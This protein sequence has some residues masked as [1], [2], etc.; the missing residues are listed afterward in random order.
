MRKTLVAIGRSVPSALRG[1]KQEH[2]CADR[3]QHA[4]AARRASEYGIHVVGKEETIDH[5]KHRQDDKNP[6]SHRALPVNLPT[7]NPVSLLH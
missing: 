7:A 2:E 5:G 3:A 1:Q 6:I 4:L